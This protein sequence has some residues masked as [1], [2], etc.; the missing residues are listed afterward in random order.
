MGGRKSGR[1]FVIVWAG[2]SVA[3]RGVTLNGRRDLFSWN[4][5]HVSRDSRRLKEHFW[6]ADLQEHTGEISS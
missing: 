5:K 3:R 6:P 4:G 2:L 1:E